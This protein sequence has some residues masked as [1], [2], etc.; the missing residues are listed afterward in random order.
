MSYDATSKIMAVNIPR[1][2]G[3]STL[4]ATLTNENG[5]ILNDMCDAR[6]L[7]ISSFLA[8]ERRSYTVSRP[9]ERMQEEQDEVSLGF[10]K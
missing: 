3:N 5:C 10:G 4:Y 6:R 2:R 7:S 9:L 8:G 1:A